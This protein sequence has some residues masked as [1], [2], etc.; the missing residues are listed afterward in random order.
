[1]REQKRIGTAPELALR[2]ALHARGHRYRVGLRVPGRSRR[3]IDIAFTRPSVAVFVDGC[4]WH[5]CPEHATSPRSNATWWAEKLA[6]NVA[7]DRDTDAHL[8]DDG[9]SVVR[10][11]EHE[12]TRTAVE[13]VE[14]ALLV[15]A[16]PARRRTDVGDAP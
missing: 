1:M 15:R 16:Q 6:T 5:A 8:R 3:T 11:W 9:W 4:F 13:L 12:L 10:V 7:R 14:A 2:R